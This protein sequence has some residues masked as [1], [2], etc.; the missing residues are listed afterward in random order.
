MLM[1][2]LKRC[3]SLEYF[4]KEFIHPGY[5]IGYID[6]NNE[7]QRKAWV[8]GY[9]FRFPKRTKEVFA[10]LWLR[11]HVEAEL[12]DA[13]LFVSLKMLA[14]CC[15]MRRAYLLC[16]LLPYNQ[17][18]KAYSLHILKAANRVRETN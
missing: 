13:E 7:E 8:T 11:K 5:D 10:A 2:V 14:C 3:A 17:I 16:G 6:Q 9:K 15:N 18:T 4:S 12:T 1:S